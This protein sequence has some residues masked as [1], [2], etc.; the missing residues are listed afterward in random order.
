MEIFP[1]FDKIHIYFGSFPKPRL[2]PSKTQVRWGLLYLPQRNFMASLFLSIWPVLR[3]RHKLWSQTP[4][5]IEILPRGIHANSPEN[6]ACNQIV[7][8]DF[9]QLRFTA[10]KMTG[11]IYFI[12]FI[13]SLWHTLVLRP[14]RR[15]L[16]EIKLIKFCSRSPV[17]LYFSI[18]IDHH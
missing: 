5:I 9:S 8:F 2:I 1:N 11:G 3:K 18:K 17:N 16:M 15:N 12:I 7:V 4:I 10:G 6:N 14:I 13:Q